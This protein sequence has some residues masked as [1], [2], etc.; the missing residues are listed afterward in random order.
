LELG[1][2]G[3]IEID[4]CLVKK[5]HNIEEAILKADQEKEMWSRAGARDLLLLTAPIPG[6]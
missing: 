6:L 3:N 1:L 4:V 5:S 2:S